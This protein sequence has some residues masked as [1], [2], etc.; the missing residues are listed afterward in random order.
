MHHRAGQRAVGAGA[1]QHRQIGLRHG[2][3]HVDV[4]RDHLGAAL[5]AGAGHVGHHVDLG[6]DHVGAPDH[7]QVG[8]RHFTG[9]GSG[10]QAGAGGVARLRRIVADGLVEIRIAFDVTQPVDAVAH[11]VAHGAGVVIGPD[12]LGAVARLGR[13][14]LLGDEIE[15]GVPGDRRKLART[16][17]A[18]A[19]QRLRQPAGMMHALGV[20]RDLGADHAGGVVVVLRAV[21]AADGA[22]IEHFDLERAG[23]RTVVRTGGGRDADRRADGLIHG[24]GQDSPAPG[25]CPVRRRPRPL[26][27]RRGCGCGSPHSRWPATPG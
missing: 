16:L 4:D 27:S 18:L 5:L 13:K 8:L 1:D 20:A 17:G 11:H 12:R 22:R 25:L 3:V 24:A 23:R 7:H 14:E 9:V 26:R 6:V 2:A 21:D 19:D 15:R 10:N